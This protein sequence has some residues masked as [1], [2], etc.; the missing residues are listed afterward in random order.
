MCIQVA[1]WYKR[2]EV[3]RSPA[4]RRP[5]KVLTVTDEEEKQP[6][7]REAE[8]IPLEAMKRF[9]SPRTAQRMVAGAPMAPVRTLK[10][11]IVMDKTPRNP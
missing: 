3:L 9:N 4:K 11:R 5:P 7:P 1:E 2:L 10:S 8:V 6:K